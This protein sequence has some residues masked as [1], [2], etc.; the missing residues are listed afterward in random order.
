MKVSGY[1]SIYNDWD[2]LKQAL[3][4]VIPYIDELVV[5]DGAYDWMSEFLYGIGRDPERSEAGVYAILA[6]VKIPVIIINRIWKNE[7]EKRLAGYESCNG[8]FVLRID[9]DEVLFFDNKELDIFMTSGYF[10]GEMDMPTYICP[11]HIVAP[12]ASEPMPK[13]GFLFRRA[14]ISAS[15]HLHYLWLVLSSDKLPDI[16][17]RVQ[18]YP[19]PLAFNAHLTAWRTPS[20]SIQRASFYTLNWSRKY[21]VPWLEAL[22]DIPL[23][24]VSEILKYFTP[25]QYYEFLIGHRLV[26]GGLDLNG[27]IV[28]NSPL[29]LA[30]EELL[31]PIYEK[32]LASHLAQ[33]LLL[34]EKPRSVFN[35]CPAHFDVTS[36]GAW[37]SIF[38]DNVA[39]L[40]LSSP[41]G[42]AT[43]VLHLLGSDYP[44]AAKVQGEVKID[45]CQLFVHFPVHP[46]GKW[47]R[48]NLE[49][50]I[51]FGDVALVQNM[52][53]V[54]SDL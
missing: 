36:T 26:S 4:S 6:E 2:I 51:W 54:G 7:I 30:Q 22:R 41:P 24:N 9:S 45:C 48:R 15:E 27:N 21:G 38:V 1:L 31:I 8:D 32:L 37:N 29:T 52:T 53:L 5:V 14:A 39:N 50:T 40:A 42:S 23:S 12:Q 19:K 34:R 49:I 17:K 11:G 3:D 33:N 47:L 16:A 25:I 10:V 44:Y 46:P 20:T 18:V 28:R 13:Q 43:A 35:G